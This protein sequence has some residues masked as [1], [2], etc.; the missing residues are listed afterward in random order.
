VC[1]VEDDACTGRLLKRIVESACGAFAKVQV[2]PD[3][4]S[5]LRDISLDPPELMLVDIHLPAL[6]GIDLTRQVKSQWRDT[7]ILIIT[8]SPDLGNF[9]RSFQAGAD[10]YLAK[11]VEPRQLVWAIEQVLKNAEPPVISPL[12]DAA[13]VRLTAVDD[14]RPADSPRKLSPREAQILSLAATGQTDKAIADSL[15]LSV[16]TV[17]S[18]W[19]SIRTK[20]ARPDRGSCIAAWAGL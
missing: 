5:A 11:P 7:R 18:H 6:S 8:A 14:P 10:G 16:F 13:A 4:E 17:H 19:K 2:Y 12:L 3:A 9:C 1:I 20:F 15:G